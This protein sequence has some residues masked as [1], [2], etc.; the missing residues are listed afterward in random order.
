LKGKCGGFVGFVVWG[1]EATVGE[2]YR[3]VRVKK[4]IG[5]GRVQRG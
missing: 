4:R 2:A 1:T 3:L 5:V